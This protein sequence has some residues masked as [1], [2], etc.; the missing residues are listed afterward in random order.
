MSHTIGETA[1]AP[2]DPGGRMIE[3]KAAGPVLRASGNTFQRQMNGLLKTRFELTS[4]GGRSYDGEIQ[5]SYVTERVRL[6]DIRF[7]PHATRL[8]AGN[9]GRNRHSFLV[10]HQVEGYARVRQ[11]GRDSEIGPNQIFFIDTSQPFEIETGEIWTRSIYLDSQFWQ[12]VFPE[13]N[14]YT[15]TALSCDTGLG[16]TCCSMI[17][18]VFDSAWEQ[19]EPMVTRLAGCLANLLA[20]SMISS[21]PPP[22]MTDNATDRTLERIRSMVRQNLSDASLD[23]A[24]VAGEVGLSV[25][26]VHAVFSR[27]GTTLMRWIWD[28][29]LQKIAAELQ[30]PVLSTRPVS[31]IAFEWGFNEA[32][33][34]SRQFKARFG[35]S[36]TSYRDRYLLM[37]APRDP[38]HREA[39][40]GGIRSGH[41]LPPEAAT[42]AT[43]ARAPVP[44]TGSGPQP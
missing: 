16:R 13:R 40:R 41:P 11:G 19:P 14:V 2:A 33:H 38:R 44:G 10:S 29:R 26:Q 4:V 22:A 31:I 7:S 17:D 34:F 30:N 9:P 25:R 36:P 23:V 28:Q 5:R 32:A 24:S 3:A 27:T 37:P 35:M 15:A 1:A 43:A 39:P 18:D 12:E 21:L 42:S 6:A 8:K 20:V